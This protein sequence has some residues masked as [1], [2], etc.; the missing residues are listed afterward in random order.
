MTQPEYIS[1]L[2]EK[3]L[4]NACTAQEV[5]LL[6]AYF[7]L[8]DDEALLRQ[9]VQAAMEDEAHT[10]S[11]IDGQ[12]M[13]LTDRVEEKLAGALR[14][15]QPIRPV[16]RRRVWIWAAAAVAALLAIGVLLHHQNTKQESPLVAGDDVPPGGTLATLTLE[17]GRVI[18]LNT[19]QDGIVVG[20]TIAYLDGT[21]VNG[22]YTRGG[23]KALPGLMALTTPKG[24]TYRLTLSDGTNVWL[25]AA[26]T[27]RY[28]AKFTGTERMV[29]L[30][31][32]AYFEVSRLTRGSDI[33][34]PFRVVS[35]GQTVEVLGTEFN[36]TAYADEDAVRTTLVEGSVQVVSDGAIE[37]QRPQPVTLRPGQQSVVSPDGTQINSV[38]V[39]M[40]TAWKDG[41]F[42]FR[43]T[44]MSDAMRQ[45]ARWYNVDVVY[46]GAV[47]ETYFFGN[48]RRDKSLAHALAILKKSGINFRITKMGDRSSIVV[49]P[50]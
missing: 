28:P 39:S 19:N 45:L 38:D 27:L 22:G 26:S 12:L 18:R 33:R 16:R 14:E 46:E 21:R 15:R 1:E 42:S 20:D 41:L 32:E 8:V 3:Y 10:P 31:G 37:T 49:L 17:D 43:E 44:E 23:G 50:N 7:E 2:F 4:R 40:F 29:E 9:L 35:K 5:R 36:I 30:E 6:F 13:A 34:V 47:P 24:G 48:I 11:G 25:N